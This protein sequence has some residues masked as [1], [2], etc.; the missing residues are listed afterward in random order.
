MFFGRNDAKAETPVLWPPDVKSWIIG[1]DSDAG[2]DW[3]QEEKG[4]TEDEMAGWH[5]LLNGR[6]FE[7]TPGDGDRQGGLAGCDSWGR[8]ESDTTEWLNWT[9]LKWFKEPVKDMTV[10][11]WT[12]IK[13]HKTTMGRS[14]HNHSCNLYSVLYL[15]NDLHTHP[16]ILAFQWPRGTERKNIG[17]TFLEIRKLKLRSFSRLT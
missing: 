9:K 16:I 6:E 5:H 7:W 2:R 17:I 15:I 8:K 3:G 13:R 14:C 12:W 10:L 4:S 1:K 11:V